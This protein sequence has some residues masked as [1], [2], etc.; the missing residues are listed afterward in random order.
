MP[1][2]LKYGVERAAVF[3][4]HAR[5]GQT[6][7]SDVDILIEYA[8]DAKKSLLV[9]VRLTNE[10]REALKKDVDVVTENSLSRFFRDDVLREAKAIL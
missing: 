2:L 7:S 4:S 6:E 8:S 10:L 1:I 3:G 5:G 9:R